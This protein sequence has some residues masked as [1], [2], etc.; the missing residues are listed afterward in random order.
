MT[1]YETIFVRRS[2][3]K[4][5]EAPVDGQTLQNIRQVLDEAEQMAG[6]SAR[7]EL[8]AADAVSQRLAPHYIL[9]YCEQSDAA[10][11]NVGY[12]LQKVDLYIQSIGLGSVWLGM[13]KTKERAENFCIML[14]FGRSDVPLRC[15]EA[16]FTRLPLAEVSGADNA[17]ARAARLA[18]SAM[19][20]QPWQLHFADGKVAMRYVGRGL[21]KRILRRKLSKIDLGIIARH[22]AL[23]LQSE[24]K[25]IQS[26]ALRTSG[27]DFAVEV[28]YS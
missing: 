23:A 4:Y 3:R 25:T 5:D 7:F 16:E 17:V 20:S 22:V 13:A 10:F 15:G 1:L 6:Q 27:E 26:V 28:A 11:A 12:V 21:M 18:P 2:V 9:A 19:N 8:A 24:G 14:A